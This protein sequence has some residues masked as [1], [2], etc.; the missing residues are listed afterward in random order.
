MAGSKPAMTGRGSSAGG[1]SHPPAAIRAPIGDAGFL[2][3]QLVLDA[4][5]RFVG[6][7]AVAQQLVDEVALGIDQFL[8]QRA[9]CCARRS[10][11]IGEIARQLPQPM[12]VA[13]AQVLD[14]L[15]GNSCVGD[16]FLQPLAS[17]S[18]SAAWRAASSRLDFVMASLRLAARQ[19]EPARITRQHQPLPDQ[20]EDDHAEGDE[21]DQV[22]VWKRRAARDDVS[23][24]AS[25]AASDTTPRTPVNARKNGP[26]QGGDGSR[27]ASAGTQ[28][29]REI[30]RRKHPDEARGDDDHRGHQRGRDQQVAQRERLRLSISARACK[31]VSRKTKPSIR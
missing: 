28:P 1:V 22:A 15:G 12:L 13:R 16:R 19:A 31:P 18:S 3:I 11:S 4:A 24:I 30:G 25:A 6:D 2:E 26:C 17:T 29:A 27:C 21:Q 14:G 8:L 5:P 23:G 7:L 10:S 9:R 20:R